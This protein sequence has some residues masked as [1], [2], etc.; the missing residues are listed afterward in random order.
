MIELVTNRTQADVNAGNEKGY[1]SANDLNRVGA[2]VQV[3]AQ[4]LLDAGV[5]VSV[6]PK[7][8]W[9]DADWATPTSMQDYLESVRTMRGA[10]TLAKTTPEVPADLER[11]TFG[12]AN[13]IESILQT[14]EQHIQN[15]ISTV[16]AGWA[17]GTAYTGFYAKEAY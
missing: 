17:T 5:Q 1:Y 16:D 2:A 4:Q 12:E 14:L 13:D 10:L 11:F 7:T 9:T 15:M 3:L 8:S 6:A